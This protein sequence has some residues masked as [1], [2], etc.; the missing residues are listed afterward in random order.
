MIKI[1]RVLFPTDFSD[2]SY[3]AL[4][5]AQS[6]ARRFNAELLLGHVRFPLL[7]G[8][9]NEELLQFFD[10][11]K[12]SK[13]VEE[14]LHLVASQ[15]E[16][17]EFRPVVKNNI[18]AASGIL[19]LVETEGI[20]LIVMATHGRTGLGHFVMG[21]V[22]EKVA[23]HSPVPVLTVSSRTDCYRSC[24]DYRRIL[25]GYDFSHFSRSAVADAL[26]LARF[27]EA[28][29]DI[30]HVIERKVDSGYYETWREKAREEAPG[31]CAEM[32]EKLDS[33]LGRPRKEGI[34][35]EVKIGNGDGRVADEIMEYTA[36]REIDLL[37]VGTH[38]FTGFEYL[39]LGSTTER[40]IRAAPCPVLTLHL[41]E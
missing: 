41:R 14:K 38:G 22:A 35:L 20:D 6:V 26:E 29:L 32:E 33:L 8:S 23:R 34:R 13:Y 10:E 27:Y 24:P 1:D 19:E 18:S 11:E 4:P 36:Y 12:Y 40:V 28:E 17:T 21:S 7:E 2:S 3:S 5:H 9:P 25:V 39:L 31:I 37:V 30:L 16:Y 15:V